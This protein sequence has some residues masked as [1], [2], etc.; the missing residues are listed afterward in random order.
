LTAW[1][2][3]QDQLLKKLVNKWNESPRV[4]TN[5]F[6]SP[7][8]ADYCSSWWPK[9]RRRAGLPENVTFHGLR[10]SSASLLLSQGMSIADISKRLGHSTVN[11]TAAIYLHGQRSSDAVAASKMDDLITRI[12]NEDDEKE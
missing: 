7:L 5:Q 2:Q 8:K 6:G 4:F 10:H 9:F 12:Q 3:E 11:T 1:K